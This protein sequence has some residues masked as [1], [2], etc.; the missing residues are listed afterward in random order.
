MW[1]NYLHAIHFSQ[2]ITVHR[3]SSLVTM[4]GAFLIMISVTTM[5]TV[6]ITVMKNAVC[7]VRYYRCT[8]ILQGSDIRTCIL[9][10][11]FSFSLNM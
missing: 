10:N 9:D 8:C 4:E 11:F 6:E 1:T 3:S 5:M 2:V 7:G